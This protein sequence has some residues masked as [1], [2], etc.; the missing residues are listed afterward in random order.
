MEISTKTKIEE[1][2]EVADKICNEWECGFIENIKKQF[3]KSNSL[4]EKQ[5]AILDRIYEKACKSQY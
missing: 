3:E 5:T 4:S 1:V 2:C